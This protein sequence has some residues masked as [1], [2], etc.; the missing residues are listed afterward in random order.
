M[1]RV[2]TILL[3]SMAILAAACAGDD[4]QDSGN[5]CGALWYLLPVGEHGLP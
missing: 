5:S 2:L 3:L 4:K 1:P